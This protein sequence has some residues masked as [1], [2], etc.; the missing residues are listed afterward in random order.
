MD[1]IMEVLATRDP[2]RCMTKMED[3]RICGLIATELQKPRNGAAVAT[4][5]APARSI[6]AASVE[7]KIGAKEQ[8]KKVTELEATSIGEVPIT[9]RLLHGKSGVS[10]SR[11]CSLGL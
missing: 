8:G 7:W 4:Q 3:G 9:D 6:R 1:C 10:L 11:L 2:H 5:S